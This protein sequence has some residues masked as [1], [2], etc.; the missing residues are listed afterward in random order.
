MLRR[1][2]T[3]SVGALPAWQVPGCAYGAVAPQ[4]KSAPLV[5]RVGPKGTILPARER[6]GGLAVYGWDGYGRDHRLNERNR[7]MERRLTVTQAANAAAIQREIDFVA[8]T[9]GRVVLPAARVELDRALRLRS[10]VELRGQGPGRTILRQGPVRVYPLTGYHNYGMVD[11]PLQSTEGLEPGMTV[12]VHDDRT[13]GSFYETFAVI[14]WV[15]DHWVG[16]DHGLEADYSGD[17]QPVLTTARPLVCGHRIHGAALR[18]LSLEGRCRDSPSAMGGCRGGAVYLANSRDVEITGVTET[19][20]DGEGLSFQMCRDLVIRDCRFTANTGNGLHPGAGSTNVLFERCAGDDNARAGF[21]FCVRANHITVRDCDFRGNASGIS[22]GTRD[23]HNLI[24]GCV[25]ETNQ[26]PGI[27]VRETPASTEVHSILIRRCHLRGNGARGGA[28]QVEVAGAAHDLIVE[29][30]GFAGEGRTPGLRLAA[31][32][33]RIFLNANE[34]TDCTTD[35]EGDVAALTATRPRLDCGYG[36]WSPA[37]FRHL[38][39]A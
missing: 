18:D 10:G 21:F 5:M 4:A 7:V 22:I 32:S 15:E 36:D 28:G 25:I 6:F 38:C 30:N 39:T 17:R 20:F 19:E 2:Y 11:V 14:T 13:H 16:L 33:E 12:C 29:E 3:H 8:R 1:G 31:E 26:G 35:I 24:E 27:L 9:G 34:F 23:C 37:V